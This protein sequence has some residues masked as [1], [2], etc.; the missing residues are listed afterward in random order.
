MEASRVLICSLNT[1]LKFRI[2]SGAVA[3]STS[4]REQQP[5]LDVM[6]PAAG[7]AW[8][9]TPGWPPAPAAPGR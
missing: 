5:I 4:I 1:V 8:A 6:K 9:A 7:A 3:E 2:D